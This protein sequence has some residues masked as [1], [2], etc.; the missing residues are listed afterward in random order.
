[1]AVKVKINSVFLLSIE[2]L[3]ETQ[4]AYRQCQLL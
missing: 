3:R 2:T 4:A 1:M